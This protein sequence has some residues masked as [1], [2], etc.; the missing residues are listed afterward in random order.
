MTGFQMDEPLGLVICFLHSIH[1][2]A[3]LEH[4]HVC[5]AS[6]HG[7]L[8]DGGV[9]CFNTVDKGQIDNRLFVRHF[10]EHRGSRFTLGFGWYYSDGGERQALRLGTEKT[11]D[12]ATQT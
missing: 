6:V 12:G 1:Y 10:M 7:A 11:T 9:S 4:L 2:N 5:L 8:T 3:G